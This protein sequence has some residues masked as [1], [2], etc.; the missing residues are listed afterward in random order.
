[1]GGRGRLLLDKNEE[2]FLVLDKEKVLQDL[3]RQV[4]H[5]GDNPMTTTPDD[6]RNEA[7]TTTNQKDTTI[8]RGGNKVTRFFFIFLVSRSSSYKHDLPSNRESARREKVFARLRNSLCIDK[9]RSPG[10]INIQTPKSQHPRKI[11]VMDIDS[12]V[13]VYK[14]FTTKLVCCLLN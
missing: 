8:V 9:A 10:C 1:M 4:T 12:P 13:D 3:V 5:R 11:C 6:E 2:V 7:A 14:S